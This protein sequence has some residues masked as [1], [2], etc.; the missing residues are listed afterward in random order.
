MKLK[1]DRFRVLCEGELDERFVR[2]WLAKCGIANNRMEFDTAPA[3]KGSGKHYVS[4]TLVEFLTTKR[5]K[6]AQ[7]RLGFIV[8]TDGD[9]HGHTKRHAKLRS[10]AE[11]SALHHEFDSSATFIPCWH[12]E[13]WLLALADKRSDLLETEPY[14]SAGNKTDPAKIKWAAEEFS[15]PSEAQLA[16]LPA[17]EKALVEQSKLYVDG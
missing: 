2:Y 16:M 1:F 13:T 11:Q 4:E 6:K 3:G 17:L 7:Q 5:S 12:I 8:I 15:A 10:I 9:E 14:K